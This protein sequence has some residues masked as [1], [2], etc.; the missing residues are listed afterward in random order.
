MQNVSAVPACF[1]AHVSPDSLTVN[2]KLALG[3][4]YDMHSDGMYIICRNNK[5][6]VWRH[7]AVLFLSGICLPGDTWATK[8]LYIFI[9]PTYPTPGCC[10]IF[11]IL[12]LTCFSSINFNLQPSILIFTPK[13]LRRSTTITQFTT[14]FLPI[15]IVFNTFMQFVL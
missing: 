13:N 10:F 12:Y 15:F 8:H 4:W 3:T 7:T 1:V 11:C 14:K 9:L 6:E 5:W 2:I